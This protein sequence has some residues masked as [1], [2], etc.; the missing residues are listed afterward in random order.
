M[1]K[2]EE[3]KNKITIALRNKCDNKRISYKESDDISTLC[4]KLNN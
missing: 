3:R 4:T 1:S 2:T